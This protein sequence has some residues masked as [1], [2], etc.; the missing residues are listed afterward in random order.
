MRH[1]P[2]AAGEDGHLRLS[3]SPW[4]EVSVDGKAAGMTPSPPIALS[5]GAHTVVLKNGELGRE[6]KRRV[7]V[8]AG[9]EAV[10]RVDLFHP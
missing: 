10:V 3:V 5:A 1:T 6:I 2:P 9:G 4:A 7:V 8:P